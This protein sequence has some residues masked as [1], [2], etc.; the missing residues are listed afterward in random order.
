MR[1]TLDIDSDVLET[2][3][4]IAAARKQP[5]GKVLSDLAREALARPK[6]DRKIVIKNGFAVLTGGTGT[7]TPELVKRL[8][9]EA[10]F[11]GAGIKLR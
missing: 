8:E 6:S 10:D 3:K 4:G 5:A 1:T 2:V 9:E 7:V 11:E